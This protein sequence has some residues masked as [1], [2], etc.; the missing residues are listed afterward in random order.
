[1]SFDGSSLLYVACLQ[2]HP[3]QT[4]EFTVF[5]V[6]AY[7]YILLHLRF[8]WLGEEPEVNPKDTRKSKFSEIVECLLGRNT[9][10]NHL[11]M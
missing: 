3:F 2:S 1:M 11:K 9:L 5:A 10:I 4:E 8:A 6:Y 7:Q